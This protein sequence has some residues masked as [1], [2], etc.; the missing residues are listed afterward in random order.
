MRKYQI[1]V[2][3]S[4]DSFIFIGKYRRDLETSNW[5]YFETQSGE[6]FHFRKENMVAILEGNDFTEK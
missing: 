4:E 2:C 1:Y 5:H 3:H 6:I